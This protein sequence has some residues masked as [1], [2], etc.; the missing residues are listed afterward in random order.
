MTPEKGNNYYIK[1]LSTKYQVYQNLLC[2][3][4]KS[5]QL[6][7]KV[8]VICLIFIARKNICVYILLF[9]N[10]SDT[11]PF[12]G[13]ISENYL[14]F[15]LFTKKIKKNM[16]KKKF[17][18]KIGLKLCVCAGYFLAAAMKAPCYWISVQLLKALI[19]VEKAQNNDSKY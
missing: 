16:K 11:W 19:L 12:S 13:E 18:K 5:C 17:Q 6:K 14:N 4:K 15:F 8:W 7:P 10:M 2:R 1:L 3:E 9:I